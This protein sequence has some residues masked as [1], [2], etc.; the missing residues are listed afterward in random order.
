VKS[1]PSSG[2]LIDAGTSLSRNDTPQA[3]AFM[4]EGYLSATTDLNGA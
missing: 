1:K 2:S 4:G 3:L